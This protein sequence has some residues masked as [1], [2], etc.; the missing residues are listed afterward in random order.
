MAVKRAF[1]GNLSPWR[2]EGAPSLPEPGE[3]SAHPTGPNLSSE[4]H[5]LTLHDEIIRDT[6][7]NVTLLHDNYTVPASDLKRSHKNTDI[8]L[9][10]QTCVDHVTLGIKKR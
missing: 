6:E 5:Q 10:K 8:K 3:A 9:L 4:L 2:C 7:L 1:H